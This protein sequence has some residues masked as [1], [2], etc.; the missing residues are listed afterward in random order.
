MCIVTQSDEIFATFEF[1][2]ICNITLFQPVRKR[3]VR[4][5]FGEWI[6][7]KDLEGRAIE[8]QIFYFSNENPDSVI[9]TPRTNENE[10]PK[11]CLKGEHEVQFQFF[12]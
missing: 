4:D 7:E 3:R 5:V 8:V 2:L 11:I 6:D 12:E 9:N 1:K 10:I